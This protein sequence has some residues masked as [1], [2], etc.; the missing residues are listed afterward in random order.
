MRYEAQTPQPRYL[1]GVDEFDLYVTP[2]GSIIAR[3][4]SR[5]GDM[6]R[7]GSAPYKAI[8]RS[9][10]GHIDRVSKA[11]QRDVVTRMD[12]MIRC[13]APDLCAK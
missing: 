10:E 3:F 12:A 5:W 6:I 7:I 11:Q 1:G 13:F 9:L 8:P 2:N 4:S